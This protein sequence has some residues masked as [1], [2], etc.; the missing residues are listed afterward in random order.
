MI[1]V[2]GQTS[3]DNVDQAEVYGLELEARTGLGR[4]APVLDNLTLGANLSL[5]QST[6]AL[7]ETELAFRRRFNP[8]APAT[9]DLQGQSPYLLNT[10][11]SYGDGRTTAGLFFNVFGR[12]LS[13]VSLAETPDVYEIARP[14]LDFTFSREVF[15]PWTLKLAAKNILNV[16]FRE[17]YNSDGVTSLV[18]PGFDDF[19]YT[20]Q[21]YNPGT[22]FSVGISFNPPLRRWRRFRRRA[23]PRF[24]AW[25]NGTPRRPGPAGAPVASLGTAAR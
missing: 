16:P 20:Y 18:P 13:R 12:R 11:L 17:E 10:N 22:T 25:T 9:R 2:N 5:T 1:T 8:D 15:G 14:E 24:E 3:F 4:F 6:I 23:A 7:S 21:E 19:R